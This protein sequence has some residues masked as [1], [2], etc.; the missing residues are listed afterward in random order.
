VTPNRDAAQA[1]AD[2]LNRR[3]EREGTQ[4]NPQHLQAETAWIVVCAPV[5]RQFPDGVNRFS[6]RDV[7]GDSPLFIAEDSNIP[8]LLCEQ[9]T[10]LNA[11]VPGDRQIKQRCLCA[12]GE[13]QK[14]ADVL[15]P[16]GVARSFKP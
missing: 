6:D 11:I 1:A 14:F 16:G 4:S 12:N 5:I 2:F 10:R 9:G 7:F 8:T 15:A 13:L 3:H